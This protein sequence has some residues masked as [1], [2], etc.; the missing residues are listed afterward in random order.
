MLSAA[1]QNQNLW[2]P[3]GHKVTQSKERLVW[4]DLLCVP[5]VYLRVLCG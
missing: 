5:S 4:P 1:R 3:Q 2:P